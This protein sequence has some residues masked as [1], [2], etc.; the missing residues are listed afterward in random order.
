MFDKPFGEPGLGHKDRL[1]FGVITDLA[2]A[3]D[4]LTVRQNYCRPAGREQDLT[5]IALDKSLHKR[6]RTLWI[7]SDQ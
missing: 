4:C 7:L 3:K 6:H 5:W 2:A 1:A